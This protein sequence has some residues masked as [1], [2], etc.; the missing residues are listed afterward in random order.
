MSYL[1]ALSASVKYLHHHIKL[2]SECRMDN[3]MWSLFLEQ[4]NDNF[5]MDE[6]ET[7]ADGTSHD[8]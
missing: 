6:V 5:F 8:M 2:T 1:I 4:W 3:K 7:D